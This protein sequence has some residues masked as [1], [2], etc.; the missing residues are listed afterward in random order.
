MKIISRY[1]SKIIV[2]VA[3]LACVA[4]ISSCTGQNV[5]KYTPGQIDLD[6][7]KGFQQAGRYELAIESYMEIKNKYPLSSE[8]VIAELEL[9]ETFYLQ[10]SYVESRAGFESFRDLHPKHPRVDFCAYRIA[11]TY[12]KKIPSTNDRDLSAAADAIISFEKFIEEYPKSKYVA[13]ANRS[14]QTC[15][16]R[17]A[18]KEYKI[19][20]FYF[21][22]KEYRAAAGRFRAMLKRHRDQGFNESALFH[23]GLCYY[24]LDE[25]KLAKE[26]LNLFLKQ[27]ANS[28]HINEAKRILKEI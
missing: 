11:M 5:T 17:L 24:E 13:K 20:K 23:L 22:T 16:R 10:G 4:T 21:K 18:D 3:L 2:S 8:A 14:I 27:H 25:Q 26:T 7:A 19:A 9:A 12:Y 6:K 15:K 1:H 28:K